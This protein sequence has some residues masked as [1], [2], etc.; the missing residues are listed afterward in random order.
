M[1]IAHKSEDGRLQPLKEHLD[2]VGKLAGG[3]ANAFSASAHANR[4]GQLHDAGKYSPAGQRRMNDPEHTQK[5]DHSTWGAQ[6]ALEKRD[7][8]SASAI[9]GHHGGLPDLG[10]RG[11]AEGDGTLLGRCKKK[12][13]G[14][15]DA[16]A[17][18]DENILGQTN[19]L[20]PEWLIAD[21]NAF[22]DQ[23]YTRMLFSCL[24]DAD[25]LD[26]EA[27]MSGKEERPRT[28][29]SLKALLDAL[30]A[31]LSGFANVPSSRINEKRSEVLADCLK[32]SSHK[33]GLFTLT[34]PTGGGKTI[35]SLAFALSHAVEHGLERVIY[36]IPYTNIIE[37][38]ARVFKDILGE[39]NVLEHHSGITSDSNQDMEN[40]GESKHVTQKML[41]AENW[42]APVIVT[43]AVQFFESLF[44][45]KPSRCRKL[46]NIAN[47][48]VIFDEAQMLP[49]NYLK[50]CVWAIAELLRHYKMS[51]VL[52]TA[53]QPSLAN[54]FINYDSSLIS[55]EIC[56]NPEA[57]QSFF[58]RVHF[59]NAGEISLNDLAD[60]LSQRRQ[61]LCIVNKRSTAQALY[62]ELPAE[63][64]FHLSTYMTPVHREQ[65]L[66]KIRT[67]L[68]EGCTCRV[69]STSLLE[70][71]V[72]VDFP[73]VWR[74][75][76]GLD[77]I[78]QAAGRCNREGKRSIKESE[79][80]I[81]SLKNISVP[82]SFQLN[83]TAADIAMEE[84]DSLDSIKPIQVYFDQL[85]RLRGEAAMDT[86]GIL[87][88]CKRCE[89]KTIADNFHI[90]EN[91][92]FTIYVPDNSHLDDVQLLHHGIMSRALM[93]RLGRIAVNVYKPTWDN[94]LHAGA[95]E[96]VDEYSG[97]LIDPV[98]YYSQQYGLIS[99]AETGQAIFVD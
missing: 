4:L 94:L 30:T 44:S 99:Q 47:S 55:S 56:R 64:S 93:R 86:K 66:E 87:M 82:L 78:L 98:M 75:K 16:S 49:L 73:E 43:T 88:S 85:Y 96:A 26:T 10:S 76:A 71:G 97:I 57:L 79:V 28:A 50:P 6:I 1:F 2:A 40:D 35:S 33:P 59:S 8:Y 9:A 65:T 37:Q 45:N 83:R 61:V 72:D 12:L 81:F 60:R 25:Y 18:W 36:V 21:R 91:D 77:S 13:S 31:H 39:E 20:L 67:A 54:L 29:A 92:T 84:G 53:T 42:D 68:C 95:L 3:F 48:V 11:S 51:A 38:N 52:C 69:V 32:A 23:F 58:K 34:V 5:V 89:F 80:S 90:I 62:Q 17:F 41:A 24:V 63:G 74:E 22:T 70:A 15:L 7:L 27:F 19:A 46:H 14:D